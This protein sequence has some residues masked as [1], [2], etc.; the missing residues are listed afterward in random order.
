MDVLLAIAVGF[1]AGAFVGYLGARSVVRYF[2]VRA[3]HPRVVVSFAAIAT[4]VIVP[5]AFFLSLG[6]GG[7]LGGA[8]GARL[9]ES[10][11]QGSTGAP[12]GLAIGIATVLAIGL[13]LGS[14][15][16]ARIGYW[17]SLAIWRRGSN[18]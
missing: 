16:G 3:K 8:F 14:S 17:I 4:L 18:V 10:L 12:I 5:I 13:I 1:I 2:L 9:S 15:I 11:N 6:I 7:N